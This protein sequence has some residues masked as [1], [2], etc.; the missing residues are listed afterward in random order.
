[1]KIPGQPSSAICPHS[2]SSYSPFSA[3]SRT[4]SSLKRLARKSRAVDL[5]ACWSSE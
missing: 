3:S 2:A 1:M 5:I 4:F